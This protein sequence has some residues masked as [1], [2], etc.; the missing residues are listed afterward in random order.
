MESQQSPHDAA[1]QEGKAAGTQTLLRGLA[2]LEQV[3]AGACEAMEISRRLHLPRSN[4]HR[5]LK[6]L[7]E[8]GYLHH[9]PYGGYSLGYKLIQ[10]GSVALEQRPYL[11]L[12]RPLLEELSRETCETIHFGIRDGVDVLYLEKIPSPQ[13]YQ[14]KSRVGQRM[15]LASTGVGKA[16]ILDEPEEK[17]RSLFDGVRVAKKQ[18]N[19]ACLL[20]PW[21]EYISRMRAYRQRGW[22]MDLEENEA[23]I[24]CVAAPVRD[25]LGHIVASISVTGL[26]PYMPQDRMM[27]LGALVHEKARRMSEN[28]GKIRTEK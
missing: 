28:F 22:V 15:P 17:L 27:E 11:D 12:A 25:V 23:G 7:T 8:A 16:L 10:L 9:V 26:V 21:E 20:P 4:V 2:V 5:I 6:S 18:A 13:A 3:A 24:K 1:V 19:E 14:T